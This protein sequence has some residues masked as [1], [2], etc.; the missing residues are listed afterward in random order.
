VPVVEQNVP[1]A[2]GNHLD[3]PKKA[4]KEGGKK[5]C[6]AERNSL[7]E[8][9][10]AILQGIGC[11]DL[12]Q[13]KPSEDLLDLTLEKRHAGHRGQRREKRKGDRLPWETKRQ[14][15]DGCSSSEGRAGCGLTRSGKEG[16]WHFYARAGAEEEGAF[17]DRREGGKR[18]QGNGDFFERILGQYIGEGD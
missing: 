4:M 5:S 18:S 9:P 11:D 10:V 6:V 13:E 12:V 7:K 1:A 8:L 17:C 14:G 2:C 16:A 3:V 15:G